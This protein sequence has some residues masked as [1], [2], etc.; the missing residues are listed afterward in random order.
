MFMYS[1]KHSNILARVEKHSNVYIFSTHFHLM[2]STIK[3]FNK[4]AMPEKNTISEYDLTR[5]DV[6]T[7]S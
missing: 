7:F 5:I 2:H 1:H 6:R 4:N 3:V